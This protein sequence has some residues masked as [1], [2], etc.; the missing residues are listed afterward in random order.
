MSSNTKI[1]APTYQS[2]IRFDLDAQGIKSLTDEII[3]KQKKVNDGIAALSPSECTFDTVIRPMGELENWATT[4][5]GSCQFLQ[6]VSTNKEIRDASAEAHQKLTDFDIEQGMREDLFRAVENVLSNTPVSTLS[7]TLPPEDLRLLNKIHLGFKRNGLALPPLQRERLKSIK[8]RISELGIQFSK[9]MNEDKTKCLFT[10]EELDGLPEDFLQGLEK[11]VVDGQEKYVVTMKYPDLFPVLKM[12]KREA[13]RKELEEKNGKKCPENVAF[14]EECVGLRLE[15]AKILG[16]ENHAQFK[17]EVKMAKNEKNVTEFLSNLTGKLRP[18]AARE[19][20]K[21]KE[22]KKKDK[23][24]L[25]EADTDGQ[26][27]AWD[28]QYYN[29]MLLEE[30]YEVDHEKIKV[31]M[32][33]L[34]GASPKQEAN[35]Q[36]EEWVL[37]SMPRSAYLTSDWE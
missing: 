34:R 14:L 1:R 3:A 20:E 18:G 24:V 26:I 16:Y 21:L 23:K 28:F 37:M 19:L 10:R 36:V 11:E 4:L 9:N 13:T 30:E 2:K 33:D 8:K 15:A 5:G 35:G 29:R 25:G 12:A 6:Y 27:R 32:L 17:L 22:L 7:Q 31:C